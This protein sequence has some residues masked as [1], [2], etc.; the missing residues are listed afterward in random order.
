M[1]EYGDSRIWR[2]NSTYSIQG[3]VLG[4]LLFLVYINDLPEDL[5]STVRLFADDTIVYLTMNCEADAANLQEDL[6]K[7]AAW[8]EKWQMRFHPKKCSILRITRKRSPKIFDYKLHG[9]ILESETNSKYLGVTINKKLSW[10]N[11]IDNT[12]K[13]AN[14]SLAFLRRNLQISQHHIKERAYTTLVR[15]QLEYAASVW[16]PYTKQKQKQIE[17][18]QRR[19]ARFVYRNYSREAS[20]TAMIEKLKWRSLMQRRAD[21][22]L[23]MLYK[24]LNGLVAVD[25]SQDL[26]PQ[27][28]PSRHCNSMSFN[29]PSET[30]QYIQQSFLPRTIVQWNHLPEKLALAPSLEAFKAGVSGLTH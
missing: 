2:H 19:A 3:S 12:C 4:P 18:V 21:I 22:R 30:K 9:H 5:R 1:V 20:V 24:C 13:K 8:E 17:M 26:I 7:L 25:L 6:D 15:P 14:A 10:N 28:R 27:S 16:D 11:H 29:I 23:I